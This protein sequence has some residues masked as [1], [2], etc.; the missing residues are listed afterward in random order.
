MSYNEL[1]DYIDDNIL[2]QAM[3]DYIKKIKEIENSNEKPPEPTELKVSTR[4]SKAEISAYINMINLINFLVKKINEDTEKKGLLEGVKMKKF[5]YSRLPKHLKIIKKKKKKNKKEVGINYYLRP[6]YCC[7][8]I[9]TNNNFKRVVYDDSKRDFFYD[10]ELDLDM[11]RKYLDN[12]KKNGIKKNIDTYV[13]NEKLKNVFKNCDLYDNNKYDKLLKKYIEY[14]NSDLSYIEEGL[15]LLTNNKREHFY[16]SCTIIIKPDEERRPVNIK[17]FA[18]GQITI[19]GGL[20]NKDGQDA[21]ISLL[22]IINVDK[23][24]FLDNDKLD[25]E[26]M[27]RFSKNKKCGKKINGYLKPK[28]T[29]IIKYDITMINSDYK[30]NFSV[31]REKLHNILMNE[32]GLMSVFDGNIYPGVKMYYYWNLF[33]KENNGICKCSNKIK[34]KGKGNGLGEHKCKKIT[35][36]I[37]QSGSV[38]ITGANSDYQIEHVHKDIKKIIEKYYTRIIKFSIKDHLIPDDDV[39]PDESYIEEMNLNNKKKK[40]IKIKKCENTKEYF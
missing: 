17:L 4:S 20:N 11:E 26:T 25:E 7:I 29:E 8:Y 5:I 28:D 22:K 6:F 24:N 19:T 40:E 31:D 2:N 3:I 15:S 16:N 33:N 36:V 27:I 37:F 38:M 10:L 13:D 39:P 23:N 35:V 18:N 32:T 1:D 14:N 21:V 34:C 9:D 12:E 30:L